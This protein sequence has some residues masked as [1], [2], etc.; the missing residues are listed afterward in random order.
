MISL[1]EKRKQEI[2]DKTYKRDKTKCV[3]C[4]CK[5]L[6]SQDNLVMH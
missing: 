5:L 2:R 3:I 4:Y 1:K 6:A